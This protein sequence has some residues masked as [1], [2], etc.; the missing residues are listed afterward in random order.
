MASCTAG[1]PSQPGPW[2]AEATK[3]LLWGESPAV[4]GTRGVS[5]NTDPPRGRLRSGGIW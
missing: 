1:T 5:V 4:Q 2:G 3:A